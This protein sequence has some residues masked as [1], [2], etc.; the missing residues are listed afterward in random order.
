MAASTCC[1]STICNTPKLPKATY[2]SSSTSSTSISQLPF[3]FTS[4]ATKTS[5]SCTLIREPVMQDPFKETVPTLDL[6]RP[7]SFGRFG[8]Y[9]GKYVPE[10]L[11][12]ALTELETAFHSLPGDVDFEVLNQN[13]CFCLVFG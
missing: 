2:S 13:P 8:K 12:H 5:I 11:M 1:S 4:R 3:K 6:P 7:D 9:G 10:T